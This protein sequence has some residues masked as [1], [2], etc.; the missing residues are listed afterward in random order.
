MRRPLPQGAANIGTWY[1]VLEMSASV[2]LL[3][4]FALLCWTLPTFDKYEEYR[5]PFFFVCILTIFTIKIALAD[6]IPDIPNNYQDVLKRH[7][8]VVEKNLSDYEPPRK[9]LEDSD[10]VINLDVKFMA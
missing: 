2:S 6:L 10:E 7:K 9:Q 5:W 3:T 4:N 1:S 8:Y